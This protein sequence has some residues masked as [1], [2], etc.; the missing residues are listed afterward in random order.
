MSTYTVQVTPGLEAG[1]PLQIFL[2]GV[3]DNSGAGYQ[4]GDIVQGIL[5]AGTVLTAAT[6]KTIST[7]WVGTV[8]LGI[9]GSTT[10]LLSSVTPSATVGNTTSG[11]PSAVCA[12]NDQ[13]TY[14]VCTIN[15]TTNTG[16]LKINV[17]ALVT[18]PTTLTALPTTN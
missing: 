13:A 16:S 18:D 12:A 14:L 6:L 10:A 17:M 15:S 9:T 1:N 7:G 4:A 5:A 3:N 8:S 2:D 11:I